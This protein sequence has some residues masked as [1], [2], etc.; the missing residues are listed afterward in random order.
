MYRALIFDAYLHAYDPMYIYGSNVNMESFASTY[1]IT[2]SQ[3]SMHAHTSL[4]E[5][6][7]NAKYA[8]SLLCIDC[9][10]NNEAV[11]SISRHI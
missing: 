2:F 5:I 1:K 10:N 7:K 9:M 11:D 3:T 8:V 6:T 4:I